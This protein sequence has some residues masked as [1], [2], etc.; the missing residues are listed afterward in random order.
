MLKSKQKTGFNMTSMT[1]EHELSPPKDAIKSAASPAVSQHSDDSSN[2]D[3][4]RSN[5]SATLSLTQ[6]LT[7]M[8]LPSHGGGKVLFCCVALLVRHKLHWSQCPH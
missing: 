2:T 1:S 4:P 6:R 7:S 8:A 5:A 3:S